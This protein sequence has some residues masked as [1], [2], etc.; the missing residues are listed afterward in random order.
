[1]N[2][3]LFLGCELRQKKKKITRKSTVKEKISTK[4]WWIIK[5]MFLKWW[6]LKGKWKYILYVIYNLS[7]YINIC[8]LQIQEN[9]CYNKE[10]W[11]TLFI[12][13]QVWRTLFI[14]FQVWWGNILFVFGGVSR[15]GEMRQDRKEKSLRKL[16]LLDSYPYGIFFYITIFYLQFLI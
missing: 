1:M 4:E 14:L 3:L 5:K 2:L 11:Q 7:F 9:V 15:K 6:R 16:P 12:L 8:S 10:N 13:F